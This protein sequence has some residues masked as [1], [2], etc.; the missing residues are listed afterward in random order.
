[1]LLWQVLYWQS[2]KHETCGVAV[3]GSILAKRET[4]D[5]AVAG[6]TLAKC[7]T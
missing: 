1:M 5:V 4:S 7:K 3:A 2:A 6:G